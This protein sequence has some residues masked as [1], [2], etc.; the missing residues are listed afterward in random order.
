M[1]QTLYSILI[2]YFFFMFGLLL[3]DKPKINPKPTP[4]TAITKILIKEYNLN[5]YEAT[6]YATLSLK[7]QSETNIPWQLIISTIFIESNFNPNAYNPN[8]KCFGLMQLK[9]QTAKNIA[10]SLNI[11]IIQTHQLPLL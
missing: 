7:L 5:H 10:N 11:N 9:Y 6:I 2:A 8:S 3:N 1:I 4:Q